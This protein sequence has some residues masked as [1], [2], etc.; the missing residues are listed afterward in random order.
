VRRFLCLL[1][2]LFACRNDGTFMSSPRVVIPG[3]GLPAE[4]VDQPA[5]NNLDVVRHEGRVYLAFRTAPNHFAGPDTVLYVV[6]S[7]D[8]QDWRYETQIHL[9]TDLREPRFLSFDRRLFLYF[10]VLGQSP[11]SFEPQGMKV[12]E[13][14]ADGTWTDPEWFYQPGFIP[15]RAKVVNGVPYLITYVGGGNI[16]NGTG[17]PLEIH[18][19]TT[20]DGRTFTPV[21]PG[22]PKVLEG[23]GSETDF[24]FQDDG[25]LVAV[26]RNEAGDASGFGSKICRAE[27]AALGA[28]H[29]AS[30][31]KKYDSP[32]LF[33]HGGDIYLIGRRNISDTGNYDLM[34]RDLPLPMQDLLYQIDYWQRPKRCS[35]WK[36]DPDALTVSFVLDLPSKGDT[37][38]AS[39]WNPSD[40]EYVV[41]NYTS[42]LDTAGDP[43]WMEGQIEPTQIVRL[44]LDFSAGP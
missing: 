15:W 29:C 26:V 41:Y 12:T 36:V 39:V 42:P 2:A 31:P 24:V 28:W 30:D 32:L 25:S 43:A 19:L 17:E 3:A 14:L 21:V 7:S 40:D 34:M 35:L 27:A 5:N 37:C 38:F 33:R 9:G 10:A 44:V 22:Q 16:Y 13:R 11:I 4:V 1:A 18:L 8:E 6:S 20:V 23:G